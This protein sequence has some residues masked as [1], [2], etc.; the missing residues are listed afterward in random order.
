M[1]ILLVEDSH[2]DADLTK[3][4]L[5]ASIPGC[6]VEVATHIS[7]ARK[8]IKGGLKF[9]IALLDIKL[10]D[11]SGIELLVEIRNSGIDTPVVILTGSGNEESAAGAMKSGADDYIVKKTGYIERLPG[12]IESA[13]RNF[14]ENKQR[15]SR[16]INVLY[17]E[18]NLSDIDLT[19]RHLK[20]FAPYINID[21]ISRAEEAIKLISDKS[22][23]RPEYDI[24]LVDYR[25]Q[26]LNAIEF[27]KVLRQ[28]MKLSLL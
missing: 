22:K 5:T 10:P 2:S 7:K 27:V 16:I 3:R 9:D 28:E 19:K 6:R 1:N 12:I 17:I 21:S 13:V 20:Q 23:N 4:G 11:G 26:G 15:L 14:H 25:L 8:L 18:H 24:I